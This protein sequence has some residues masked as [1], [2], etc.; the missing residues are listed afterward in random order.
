M[1]LAHVLNVE[2]TYQSVTF[3]GTRPTEPDVLRSEVRVTTRGRKLSD[4]TDDL[5]AAREVTLAQPKERDDTRLHDEYRPWGNAP[6]NNL[7]CWF[8]VLEDEISH[9]GQIK[10]LRK[11]LELTDGVSGR[12]GG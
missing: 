3:H 6:M 2:P 7:F 1:L 8:H 4:Y 5:T 9:R 12:R 10:L 11:Q